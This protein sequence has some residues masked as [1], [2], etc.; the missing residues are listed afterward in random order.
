MSHPLCLFYVIVTPLFYCMFFAALV[1]SKLPG[2]LPTNIMSVS[3]SSASHGVIHGLSTFSRANIITRC[4]GIDSTHVTM[5]RKGV[6]KFFCV[7]GNLSTRT[8]DRQRPAVS[9][10]AG[11]SCL[12]TNSLLFESVGVLKRLATNTTTQAALCTGNTARSRTV[13]FLRPVIVSARP[14]GGP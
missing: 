12:V 7:P 13:K 11:C 4:D 10:C 5:R 1:S 8:R 9:F 14:L 2:S 3:S 6:C